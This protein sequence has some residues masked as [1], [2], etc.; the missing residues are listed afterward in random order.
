MFTTLFGLEMLVPHPS[1]VGG[2]GSFEGRK[3][4]YC[5][6]W[7]FPRGE[8]KKKQRVEH[9]CDR[10]GREGEWKRSAKRSRAQEI[11]VILV[12]KIIVS[13]GP[14][15]TQWRSRRSGPLV[16]VSGIKFMTS[17]HI[18]YK[19]SFGHGDAGLRG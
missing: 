3:S 5:A 7:I 8:G 4:G 17:L 10:D 11:K 15:A 6:I 19:I 2:S 12:L 16:W 9:K 14:L 13:E 1:Q 18:I